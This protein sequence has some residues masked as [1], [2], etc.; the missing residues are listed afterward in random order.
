MFTCPVS[1]RFHEADFRG[2]LFFGRILQLAH[3]VYEDFVVSALGVTWDEYFAAPDWLVPI[4]HAEAT[5]HRPLRPG[6]PFVAEVG[7]G[8]LS[9]SS[10]DL[11]T[12][13]L[14]TGD[15]S[16]HLCAE[17]RTV[18]VFVDGRFQKTPIPATIRAR[19]ER[20]MIADPR[21]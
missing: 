16:P 19:L 20:H 21:Q 1:V 5:F 8:R 11:V 12:R 17:T 18:H 9:E 6:R 15:P 7:V 2:I 4:K 10:F 3:E 13:F 14:D